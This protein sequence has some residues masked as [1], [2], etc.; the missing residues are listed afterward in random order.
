MTTAFPRMPSA[1]Y[2][3]Q[4]MLSSLV[5]HGAHQLVGFCCSVFCPCL[6]AFCVPLSSLYACVVISDLLVMKAVMK[7]VAT[8]ARS[9]VF[10]E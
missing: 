4:Y 7:F 6:H 8:V 3:A 9:A 2:C 1:I 5:E 10:L